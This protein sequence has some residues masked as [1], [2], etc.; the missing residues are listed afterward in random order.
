MAGTEGL[1]LSPYPAVALPERSISDHFPLILPI[2][3]DVP[4]ESFRTR[5]LQA[6]LITDEEWTDY[7]ENLGQVLC[8]VS[9]YLSK[10]QEENNVDNYYMKID[11]LLRGT[12]TEHF[13]AQKEPKERGPLQ[14]FLKR[15]SAHPEIGELRYAIITNDDE[16]MERL[17]N[18]I[19]ADGW[20]EFQATLS[21]SN[22]SALYSYLARAEGRGEWDLCLL[23]PPRSCTR[24]R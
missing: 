13:V 9:E 23:S 5:K 3:C 10:M 22:I 18:R 8:E 16:W 2:P 6:N 21:R 20:R 24:M 4:K 1:G 19:E 12:L 17:V 15:H 14:V 11:S 7:Q